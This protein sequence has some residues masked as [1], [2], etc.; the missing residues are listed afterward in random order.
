MNSLLFCFPALSVRPDTSCPCHA[1]CVFDRVGLLDH[2]V[3]TIPTLCQ[4][5]M[6]ILV[7]LFMLHHVTDILVFAAGGRVRCS[8]QT[9][10]TLYV[11]REHTNA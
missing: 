10:S 7:T 2:R 8:Q 9:R 5:G 3:H 1:G 6:V 4:A 11:L